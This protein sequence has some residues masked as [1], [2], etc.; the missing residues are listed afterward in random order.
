LTCDE[1]ATRYSTVARTPG[2]LGQIVKVGAFGVFSATIGFYA[3]LQTPNLLGL[4]TAGYLSDEESVQAYR[5]DFD[6][7]QAVEKFIENHTLTNELRKNPA[8]IESRPHMKI[9]DA[10]RPVSLTAGLL[11]GPNKM[12]VPPYAWADKEGKAL[13]SIVYIGDE[14]CGH[15]GIIHGGFIATMLDE[16]LATC[17][18]AALPHKIGV[19]ANLNINYRKPAR[20]GNYYVLRAKTTNVDGRK[21]WVEGKLETLTPDGTPGVV[22][23][24][25]T[26]LFISPKYAAVRK[27]VLDAVDHFCDDS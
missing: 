4:P 5:P 15:P 14:L 12:V 27:H 11:I 21:A 9:P 13:V 3:A 24:D 22:V 10:I 7:A 1:P 20:A 18:F 16:G 8:M 26:A 25:A 19:T 6:Q 17:C 23:A 2:R